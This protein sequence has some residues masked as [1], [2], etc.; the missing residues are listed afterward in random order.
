MLLLADDVAARYLHDGDLW[1]YDGGIGVALTGLVHR[2]MRWF[3]RD[4]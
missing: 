4:L 3:D 1:V 2:D